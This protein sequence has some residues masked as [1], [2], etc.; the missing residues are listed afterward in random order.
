MNNSTVPVVSTWTANEIEFQ[1]SPPVVTTAATTTP[2]MS[3]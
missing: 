1:I 2:G 3:P